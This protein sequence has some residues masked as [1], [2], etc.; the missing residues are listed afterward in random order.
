MTIN[1][2]RYQFV[3][4]LYRIRKQYPRMGLLQPDFIW[5][6]FEK[7]MVSKYIRTDDDI[8]EAVKEWF[9]DAAKAEV[10]Y[11][12]ISKWNTSLVTNM[13]DLFKY[14]KHF[15][16]D[17]SEW[18]VS[19]VIDFD[20]EEE[21]TKCKLSTTY[22]PGYSQVKDW[23]IQDKHRRWNGDIRRAVNMWCNEKVYEWCDD[24]A[25]ATAKYGHISKWDTS[26]VTNM[27]KLFEYKSDF[28]DDISKWNVSNVTSV[29]EMFHGAHS[30]TFDL[31]EWDFNN[32]ID[33]N[34]REVFCNCDKLSTTKMPGYSQVKDWVIQDKH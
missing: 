6:I 19:N 23:V 28:N 14:E 21:F 16:D 33:L 5:V 11:G 30:F 1:K 4:T 18:D 8:N 32:V 20:Y 31:T 29:D 10:K 27:K 13:K 15:N 25:I 22:W 2:Q 9:K 3:L 7:M 26:M 24:P 12:H 34:Y 17:I